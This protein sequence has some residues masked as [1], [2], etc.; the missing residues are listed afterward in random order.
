MDYT[1]QQPH[2]SNA[3]KRLVSADGSMNIRGQSVPNLA[4]KVSGTV[5]MIEG[6]TSKT[7]TDPATSTPG[8]VPI[9]KRRRQ[10]GRE[11]DEDMEQLTEAASHEEGRQS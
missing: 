1:E 5:L 4:G 7:N 9:V 10:D 6:A 3:R 11:G 2:S 8:K